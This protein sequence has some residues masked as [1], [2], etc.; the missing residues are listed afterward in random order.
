MQVGILDDGQVCQFE[1]CMENDF[2]PAK[3]TNCHLTFC[4]EHILRS[5]H[6]C[7]GVVDAHPLQCPLCNVVLPISPAQSPDEIVSHHI[8]RGCLPPPKPPITTSTTWTPS[9]K[10]GK[11]PTH[12]SGTSTNHNGRAVGTRSQPIRQPPMGLS[13]AGAAA[14][15]RLGRQAEAEQLRKAPEPERRPRDDCTAWG[16]GSLQKGVGFPTNTPS[17]SSSSSLLSLRELVAQKPWNTKSTAV[18]RPLSVVK[19]GTTDAWIPL[20]YTV[21]SSSPSDGPSNPVA[22]SEDNSPHTTPNK[23]SAK[24]DVS[25]T[26]PLTRTVISKPSTSCSASFFSIPPMYI[27]ARRT[28]VLGKILDNALEEIQLHHPCFSSA[29]LSTTPSLALQYL[30][31]V[32]PHPPAEATGAMYPAQPLST[33]LE[34]IDTFRTDVGSSSLSNMIVFLSNRD[35]LPEELFGLL[36]HRESAAEASMCLVC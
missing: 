23:A 3:C 7:R 19:E 8:D 35:T 16:G 12:L 22:R 34:K 27:Y 11:D 15:K 13:P 17:F 10:V 32:P 26:P 30:F 21:I 9:F 20:V 18:G 36:G 4:S 5:S 29:R 6:H 1:G 25:G 2:L 14:L 28:H 24:E 33:L 31:L